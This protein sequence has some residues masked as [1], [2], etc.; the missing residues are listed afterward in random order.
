MARSGRFA[1]GRPSTGRT[2]A[3][4]RYPDNLAGSRRPSRWRRVI[5]CS[6]WAEMAPPSPPGTSAYTRA[7]GGPILAPPALSMVVTPLAPH[8][9]VAPPLVVGPDSRVGLAVE[10]GYGGSRFELDGQEVATA[11]GD[12][13]V[14]L[15]RDYAT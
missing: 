3:R 9:G 5:C 7:A 6:R 8:G 4:S 1:I 13:T 14:S 11:V 12:I 10:P 15:R 2:S